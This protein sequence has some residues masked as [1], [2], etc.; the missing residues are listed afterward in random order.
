MGS[1][2]RAV[3]VVLVGALAA[4][5]ALAQ[6]GWP[7]K[8]ITIIERDPFDYA[9]P[10]EEPAEELPVEL[11]VELPEEPK[12]VSDPVVQARLKGL[13][14]TAIVY[15][16]DHYEAIFSDRASK[17]SAFVR[18][19]RLREGQKLE[20]EEM[21]GVEVSVISDED[22]IVVLN[23]MGEKFTYELRKTEVAAG[24]QAGRPGVP[25]RAGG[26]PRGGARAG[27]RSSAP[28]TLSRLGASVQSITPTWVRRYNLTV[29]KGVVVY[30]VHRGRPAEKAGLKRGD[31]I[32][33]VNGKGVQSRSDVDAALRSAG[34]A[35]SA[36]LG[37]LRG[38]SNQTITISTGG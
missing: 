16:L 13:G 35:A 31:V 23:Y 10:P 4:A 37:I 32:T 1:F 25:S 34:T 29:E 22:D 19:L 8:Y 9:K 15:W 21:K 5:G 18:D 2:R 17:S 27:S 6:E 33:S 3:F 7:G 11:P 36:A 26:S 20:N 38:S 14:L 28:M 24:A 12:V 30:S